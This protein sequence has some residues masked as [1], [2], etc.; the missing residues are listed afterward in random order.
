MKT[1][2]VATALSSQIRA[3]QSSFANE[4]G[5]IRYEEFAEALKKG[6]NDRRTSLV[7]RIYDKLD[8]L[9]PFDTHK[10]ETGNPNPNRERSKWVLA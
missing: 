4:N 10:S 9:L 8:S 3:V 5:R 7:K 6:M 1:D 2:G